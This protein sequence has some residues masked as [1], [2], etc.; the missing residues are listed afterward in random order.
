[1]NNNNNNN[2]EPARFSDDSKKETQE[3]ADRSLASC[4]T[5]DYLGMFRFT[6][7]THKLNG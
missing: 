6:F 3:E 1:M 5:M 4:K 2:N 7:S